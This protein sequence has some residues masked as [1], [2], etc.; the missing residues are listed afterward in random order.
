MKILNIE[1]K[2]KVESLD[3]YE[4]QLIQKNPR[5][6]GTDFQTDTYF[7]VPKGRL[8]LRE[9]NIENALIFYERPD[10]EVAKKSDILLYKHK[11]DITLKA[12][13]EL[14]FGIKAVVKK[15]RK[16]YFVDHVKFHFDQVENLG[17]FVEIEVIDETKHF[18]IEEMNST[19]S[20]WK[21]YLGLHDNM[22]IKESY[23]DM[24]MSM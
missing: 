19:L 13:L 15:S 5:F 6:V 23:S 8:K 4:S 22:L 18:S 12:I 2:A 1:C 20:Y 16:I 10:T 17:T 9:G 7:D 3:S 21:T 24:I 14:Q 11:P